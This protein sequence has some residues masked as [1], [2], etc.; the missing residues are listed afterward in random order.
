MT[1]KVFLWGMRLVTL[2]ALAVGVALLLFTSPYQ[3]QNPAEKMY[4]HIILFN[5]SLFFALTGLF[6]LFIYWLRKKAYGNEIQAA[7]LGVSFRQGLLLALCLI[8]LMV[9]QSFRVLIWWDGLLA[10]GAIMMV[11][12]YF[13]AR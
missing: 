8:V 13:L 10:L 9:L 1:I 3:N 2:L 11:E 7:H 4:L 5:I 12:L 6:S